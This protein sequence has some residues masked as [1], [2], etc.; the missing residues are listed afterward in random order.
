M[1]NTAS[2]FSFLDQEPFMAF[3]HRG[4]CDTAHENT[5][6]SF[7]I[8]NS[9]G[10][11]N[12]ELDVHASSDGVVF[13]C[14][15]DN[16]ERVFGENLFLSRLTSVEISALEGIDGQK[17]PTL[18]SIIEEFPNVR[19]NIDAKSWKAVN[20]LCKLITATRCHDR[21]CIGGFNDFRIYSIIKKLGPSVCYSLGPLGVLNCY[22]RFVF[23]KSFKFRA[24]CLQIPES[25]LGLNLVSNKFIEFVHRNG[26]LVHIW[27]INE[28]SKMRQLIEFGVDGI[29]TDNC[30]GLKKVLQEYQ[31]WN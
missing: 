3:A 13:V 22:L 16:L 27:T 12:F 25:Y 28:E 4:A 6:E 8:A 14:H 5:M 11:R 29:M 20:P 7:S 21:I 2:D 26:L 18:L 17:V 15:D 1:I 10:F 31:L 19:L 24:G 9:L 30:V 23:R